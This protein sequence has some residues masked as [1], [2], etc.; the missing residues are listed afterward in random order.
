MKTKLVYIRMGLAFSLIFILMLS[1]CK[2]A[3]KSKTDTAKSSSGEAIDVK[4]EIS[5][6]VSAFIYDIPSSFELTEM[7]NKNGISYMIGATN[8]PDNIDHYFTSKSKAINM[9]IYG[10]DLSYAATYQMTQETM[11]Y[12]KAVNQL[13]GD[14]GISSIYNEDMLNRIQ[15]NI[16]NKDTL[17]EVISTTL[18][19]T[20]DF[21]NK[22]DKSELSIFMVAGGVVEG[23]YLAANSSSVAVNGAELNKI[24]YSQKN[25]LKKLIELLDHNKDNQDVAAIEEDLQPILR[26]FNSAQNDT[27]TGEEVI[28][29]AGEVEKVRNKM[30][31]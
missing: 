5:D 17:V 8:L 6:N 25:A 23:L 11:L 16:N 22:N 12:L 7:L 31:S 30:I 20:Y 1:S 14:L 21:L 2:N 24:I 27:F 4:K 9:G 10:T 28:A 26:I 29:L 19:D 13:G 15:D 18:L 3:P